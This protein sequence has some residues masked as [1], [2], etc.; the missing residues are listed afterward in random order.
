MEQL[1]SHA[2]ESLVF[3]QGT[4]SV[5]GN[6]YKDFLPAPDTMICGVCAGKIERGETGW[7]DAK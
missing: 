2:V 3:Y 5:C 1:I 6:Q 4:C 7:S